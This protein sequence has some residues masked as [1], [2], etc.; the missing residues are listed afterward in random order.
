ME[1]CQ[2]KQGQYITYII[3]ILFCFKK[4]EIRIRIQCYRQKKLE[5]DSVMEP[6]TCTLLIFNITAKGASS[7]LLGSTPTDGETMKSSLEVAKSTE[8]RD[9][10]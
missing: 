8:L 3:K 4:I 2:S 9:R 6:Y 1:F 10:G 7:S 5:S